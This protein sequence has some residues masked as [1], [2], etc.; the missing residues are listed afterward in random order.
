MFATAG[1]D[2]DVDGIRVV[3]SCGSGLTACI[4]AIA[5]Y[6]CTGLVIPVYDGSFAEWGQPVLGL[7]VEKS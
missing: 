6:S 7:P 5:V 2:L 4:L 3:G 1:V